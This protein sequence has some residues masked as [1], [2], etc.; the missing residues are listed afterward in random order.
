[1]KLIDVLLELPAGLD[2]IFSGELIRPG[3]RAA[4]ARPP[5]AH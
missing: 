3:A 2:S 5:L 4:R 1:M